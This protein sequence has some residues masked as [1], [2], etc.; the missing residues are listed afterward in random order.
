MAAGFYDITSL[1]E[2]ARPLS[3]NLKGGYHISCPF[4]YVGRG[5]VRVVTHG[6]NLPRHGTETARNQ[7][8]VLPS[9]GCRPK[10]QAVALS[11]WCSLV[12]YRSDGIAGRV[13]LRD[14]PCQTVGIRADPLN[15]EKA[16]ATREAKGISTW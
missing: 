12:R 3:N 7:C 5:R 9:Q 6:L 14:K 10:P 11:E 16:R 4:R 8:V 15:W 2:V 13:R 1:Y